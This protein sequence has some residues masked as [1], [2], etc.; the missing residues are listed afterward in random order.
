MN[1][2]P[3]L[4]HSYIGITINPIQHD[5]AQKRLKCQEGSPDKIA[6][7]SKYTTRDSKGG[8][9]VQIFCADA[10]RPSYW[11]NPIRNAINEAHDTNNRPSE[12]MLASSKPPTWVLAL[13]T[14][15]HFRPSRQPLF[16]HA[17][18]HLNASIMAFDLL[19]ADDTSFIDRL[20]LGLITVVMSCP[21]NAF[22]TKA[23]YRAQLGK[24]GY[25]D[26]NVE[27]K[28]VSEHVFAGLAGFIERRDCELRMYL[29]RGI[30]AYRAFGWVLRWWVWSG[31]VRG[32]IIVA[33]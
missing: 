9:S 1:R 10:A 6:N 30:G 4:I 13:D 31:V 11:S 14:L 3:S 28:D 7:K 15:Y 21:R 33:R 26:K 16:N 19:L 17:F 5:L 22:V 24:A 27:M 29:G 18:T 12:T 8:N 32:Y 20:F 23:E 2:H 25:I